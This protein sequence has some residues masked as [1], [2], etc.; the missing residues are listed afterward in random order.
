MIG[1]YYRGESKNPFENSDDGKSDDVRAL[2]WGR[3]EFVSHIREATEGIKCYPCNIWPDFIK[4]AKANLKER[5][6][7][8]EI[9]YQNSKHNCGEYNEDWYSY[10]AGPR[11]RWQSTV[12]KIP[13]VTIDQERYSFSVCRDIYGY[14]GGWLIDFGP[15]VS[16]VYRGVS[17]NDWGMNI[18]VFEIENLRGEKLYLTT[19]GFAFRYGKFTVSGRYHCDDGSEQDVYVYDRRL[20]VALVKLLLDETSPA[21]C[22][23]ES[24]HLPTND[25][26]DSEM[27]WYRISDYIS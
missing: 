4:R 10:F 24:L 20:H 26:V 14:E 23:G 1:K 15:I 22:V 3:E 21:I 25:C 11:V 5:G 16:A 18:P 9:D 12:F 6:F 2:Y 8:F 27:K 13:E 17:D 19:P 7:A